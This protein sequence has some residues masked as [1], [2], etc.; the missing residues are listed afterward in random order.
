MF[1]LFKKAKTEN[2]VAPV[3]GKLISITEVSD[4]V[5]SQK[6]M[7]DGYAVEPTNNKIFAPVSGV[8][9]TI[10]PTK[11]AVGITTK[12]GLEVLVHMGLD[13]VELNGVPFT[14]SVSQNNNI[15]AGDPLAIMDLSYV[16]KS[17]KDTTIVIV[18]TNMDKITALPNFENRSVVH[19]DDIGK[20]TYQGK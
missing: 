17:K 1:K 6:M 12:E 18:F 8:I 7:G 10:F 19:G 13:T 4:D 2:L 11:H 20:L 9:S 14:I 5:F 16:K 3:N 15:S